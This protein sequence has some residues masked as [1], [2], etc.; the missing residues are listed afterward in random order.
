TADMASPETLCLH[1]NEYEN[2][3]KQGFSQLR[4]CEDFFDVTLTCGGPKPIKAHRVIL[5]ACSSFFRSMLKSISHPHP[6]LYLRGIKAKHL[7]SI[8]AFMY[9]GEVRVESEELDEFLL[10]AQ[11]LRVN[12]L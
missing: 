1:W 5:S 10:C 12:G 9:N 3:I 6:F 4:D 8:L 7:E 2:N 11:D